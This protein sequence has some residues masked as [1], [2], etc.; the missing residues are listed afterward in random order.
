MVKFFRYFFGAGSTQEF[1]LFTPAHFV[2][3]VLMLAVIWLIYKKEG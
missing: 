2:P 3:I 1:A